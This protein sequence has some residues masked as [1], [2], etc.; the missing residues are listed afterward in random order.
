MLNFLPEPFWL[1]LLGRNDDNEVPV[2]VT[3]TCFMR[4]QNF[5]LFDVQY[6][7]WHYDDFHT[8]LHL[9]K[10]PIWPPKLG[11]GR[12]SAFFHTSCPNFGPKF[13]LETGKRLC[14][15]DLLEFVEGFFF[16]L[17]DTPCSDS[18]VVLWFSGKNVE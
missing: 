15:E 12:K 13:G 11:R 4:K 1:T 17:D 18:V 3:S 9:T 8:V 10:E 6:A 7:F 5:A 16:N 14:Y 2:L